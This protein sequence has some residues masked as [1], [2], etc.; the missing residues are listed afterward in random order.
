ML[1]IILNR[2]LNGLIIMVQY[3]KQARKREERRGEERSGEEKRG[4]KEKRRKVIHNDC[5]C[6]ATPAPPLAG[7]FWRLYPWGPWIK[8]KPVNRSLF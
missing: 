2:Q 4:G 1:H 6:A 7:R 3:D 8:V 5:N